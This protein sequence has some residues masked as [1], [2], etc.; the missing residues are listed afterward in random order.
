MIKKY[1]KMMAVTVLLSALW[2]C[3]SSGDKSLD[4]KDP[5]AEKNIMAANPEEV[6]GKIDVYN[7]ISRAVKY[8]VSPASKNMKQRI[9]YNNQQLNARDLIRG[10]LNVKA[11]A[12][13]Q[14]YDALR[15]L[16]FAVV[17][18]VDNLE[19]DVALKDDYILA[20]SSQHLALAAIKAHEDALFGTKKV[21]EIDREMK[22]QQRILDGLNEKMKRSGK[23]SN[24][25]VEYKK[26]LEVYVLELVKIRNILLAGIVQYSQLV[27]VTEKELKLEGRRFYEL[28]DFDRNLNMASFQE[29]AAENRSE[30]SRAKNWGLNTNYEAIHQK[31]VA[32]YPEVERLELNGYDIKDPIYIDSLVRRGTVAAEDLT[33]AVL[34][35]R[36]ENNVNKKRYMK[37]QALQALATAV[38]AQVEIAYN[39][40]NLT[41]ADLQEINEKVMALKKSIREKEKNY[42]Q[43]YNSRL[44]VQNQKLKLLEQEAKASQVLAERAVALRSLYFYAGFQPF[45]RV[46]LGESIKII[47]ENLKLAFNHDLVKM[48]SD[49]PR[50]EAVLNNNPDKDWSKGDD[51]LERVMA[52]KNGKNKSASLQGAKNAVAENKPK[53]TAE[54][55]SE[56]KILQLGAY[57]ERENANVEWKMLKQLYPELNQYSPKIERVTV[58]G[59]KYYRL[60]LKSEN[61]GW[62]NL[63]NKLKNDH[64][65]CLLR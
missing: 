22:K 6:K 31:V 50:N 32:D 51:W 33:A 65:E 58:N 37:D 25:E 21:Q 59:K 18:A 7:S 3:G 4:L 62:E 15:V 34:D 42:R 30:L 55:L 38:F 28:D 47:T 8:N 39:M 27:K 54:N 44:E 49:S 52:A 1:L 19:D 35:Y 41:S 2:A 13:S 60:L 14:L 11:G 9:S 61:G 36:K 43:D 5:E 64:F 46:L 48:L 24:T 57:A 20:K 10:V 45:N 26:G 40:V 56:R 63:C 53:L 12:Q 17:F 23:L 29:A 16:D